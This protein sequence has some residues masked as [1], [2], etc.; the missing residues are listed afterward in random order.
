M[1]TISR[2]AYIP[3][4][5]FVL[6]VLGPF[7]SGG[8]R[9]HGV[10]FNPQLERKE[11]SSS[12]LPNYHIHK[13]IVD[14]ELR[15]LVAKTGINLIDIQILIPHTLAKPK[16]PPSDQ[17]ESITDWANMTMMGNIVAFLDQCH[18]LGIQVEIDLATNMWIPFSVD[19][20]N[21]IAQSPWWPEPDDTPWTESRIWYKQIIEFVESKIQEKEVIALWCMFGNYQFG[22]AEP[23]L[24]DTPARPDIKRYTELFVKNAWPVF[25]AAGVRPK[26]APILLP[27]FSNDPTWLKRRPED[28]LGA[29]SNLK[30]W[31]VDDL[32]MPPDYWLISTYTKSDPATDEFRY[33]EA[34]VNI[35]GKKSCH[36]II[37]T[38]F[39]IRGHDL[40]DS[41]IDKAGMSNA[42]SLKWNLQKVEEYGFAGWWMWCYRDTVTAQTG[43]RDIK[44]RWQE[45]LVNVFRKTTTFEK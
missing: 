17:S 7:A 18:K 21:H 19:R 43:I 2:L 15:E 24:W 14:K 23:V 10:F 37:S 28:R 36:K 22:G 12:W 32:K 42:Q 33:L 5:I 3:L 11:H 20:S 34:I 1:T 31:L 9:F 8:E 35:I 39:K 26:G 41:I 25:R 13:T 29:V 45:D 38:D 40:N 16:V 4:T 6:V 27:I 30:G 44:G